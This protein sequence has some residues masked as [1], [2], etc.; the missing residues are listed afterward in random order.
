MLEETWVDTEFVD[1]VAFRHVHKVVIQKSELFFICMLGPL[2]SAIKIDETNIQA[3][4]LHHH[5]HNY[6]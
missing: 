1:V 3:A 2:S 6:T 5:L 4:K